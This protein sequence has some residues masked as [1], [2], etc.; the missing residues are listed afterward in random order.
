MANKNQARA[1]VLSAFLLLTMVASA[2]AGDSGDAFFSDERATY[3]GRFSIAEKTLSVTIDG[4]TYRG[5]FVEA[6]S[7]QNA[8]AESAPMRSAPAGLWGRAFLFAS[9]ANVLQCQLDSGFPNLA[10]RCVASNGGLFALK[11]QGH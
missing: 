7:G 6:V 8:L 5:G 3:Q 4:L 1:S 2:H 9:S 11:A 10:G